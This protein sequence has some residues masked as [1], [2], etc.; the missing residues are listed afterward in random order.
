MNRR[1]LGER[2][3]LQASTLARSYYATSLPV[4]IPLDSIVC[5]LSVESKP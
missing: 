3:F 5:Q 4:Q 2:H 1:C